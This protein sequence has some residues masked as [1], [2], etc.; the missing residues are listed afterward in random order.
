M[1]VLMNFDTYG[2]YGTITSYG[3]TVSHHPWDPDVLLSKALRRWELVF[4][5]FRHSFHRSS[6]GLSSYHPQLNKITLEK[7]CGVSAAV[8]M[9]LL[10]NA[11]ASL[12]PYLY[13]FRGVTYQNNFSEIIISFMQKPYTSGIGQTMQKKKSWLEFILTGSDPIK[14]IFQRGVRRQTIISK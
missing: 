1:I 4:S 12:L 2:T 5:P 13:Y 10:F 7:N 3:S 11:L 14:I 9:Y 8:L 6:W